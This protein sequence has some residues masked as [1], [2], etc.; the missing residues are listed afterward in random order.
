M[1]PALF[2]DATNNRVGVNTTTPSADLHIRGQT[3]TGS[4]VLT[5][6]VNDS[7]SQIS[8]AENTTNT[9]A[10]IMRYDGPS[11]QLHFL[12]NNGGTESAPVLSIARSSTPLIGIGTTAPQGA[13][14]IQE[15]AAG[16]IAPA[17]TASLVLERGNHNYVHMYAPDDRETGLLF[18]GDASDV[19]GAIVFNNSG[20]SE[21]LQFRTGGNTTRMAITDDGSVGIGV[22]SPT[23]SLEVAGSSVFD[24]VFADFVQVNGGLSV[25]DTPFNSTD[26][27]AFISRADGSN[28]NLVNLG[29]GGE[30]FGSISIAGGTVSYNAFTGSHYA[31]SR[32]TIPLGSLVSMT[33][34]N[35]RHH[36]RP[37]GEPIYGVRLS[38]KPNDPACLGSFFFEGGSTPEEATD[39]PAL[40]AAVGNGE[41]WVVDDG[42]GDIEPGDGLISSA[43]PGHAA[44]DDPRRFGVA[45]VVARSTERVR[46]SDVP[47]TDD[48]LRRRKISVLF[49][50]YVRADPSDAAVQIQAMEDRLQKQSLA[51]EEL[52]AALARLEAM[53]S[54]TRAEFKGPTP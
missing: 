25:L 18:G 13:L 3:S 7:N 49:G 36:D 33:G 39:R 23:L 12:G 35:R 32:E 42:A 9:F 10:M 37:D 4:L 27:P 41:V 50:S 45:Y 46:W 20:N 51:I 54:L 16:T 48:G 43:S 34:E 2:V 1:I 14:H 15:G 19:R 53:Q 21:G 28:G 44:K 22:L 38:T 17:A 24:G 26:A 40:V 52:Q 11:N 5:P 30:F 31:W 29:R 47:K 6:N 8:L